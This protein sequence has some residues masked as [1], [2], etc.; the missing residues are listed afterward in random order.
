MSFEVIIQEQDEDHVILLKDSATNTFA[1]V[2]AFGAILNKFCI[3]QNNSE[4]N[5]IDGFTNVA[6]AKASLTPAFK[7]AKLSPFVCRTKNEKY[8]FGENNYHLS[9]YTMG[10]NAIHGLVYDAVFSI[11]E[12]SNN[13]EHACVKLQHVYDNDSEGYP[14]CYRC[15]IEYKLKKNNELVIKTTITNVDVQLMPLADGWH[16]YFTL[17][18]SV[19]DYQLEF[20]S[21]EILEFDEELIPTGKLLPYQ[22]FGSIKDFGTTRFDNCFTFNFAECQP[23]CVL[24]N[25]KKHVQVEIHPSHEYPYL[26]IY[27]PDDRK[28]IALENLSAAPDAFN[29]SMGLKVLEPH[30][31]ATFITKF[32]IRTL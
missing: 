14:F 24:R 16:P 5:V 17:G 30:E 13:D 2:F 22:E 8:H 1:E 23:M 18:D 6:D 26:Q 31:T 12:T 21:K 4:L 27:T 15:E 20:Q 9:K 32:V 25:P 3:Q 19:N 11:I 7:G 29:N 28:S 10:K